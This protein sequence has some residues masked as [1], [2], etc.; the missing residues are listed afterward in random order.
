MSAVGQLVR[1]W[2]QRRRWSQAA[3]ADAAEVSARHLSCIETGK[4]N[5]SQQMVLVLASALDIPLRQR[6]LLLA[7]AG[8]APAY[9]ETDLDA[10]EMA[11]V[12]QAVTFLLDQA[13]PNG[14]ALVDRTYTLLRANR[15]LTVLFQAILGGEIPPAF[16]VCEAIFAELRPLCLNWNEVARALLLRVHREASVDGDEELFALLERMLAYDNVPGDWLHPTSPPSL[17]VPIELS[18]MGTRVSLF[19]T[20]TTLGTPTDITLSELRIE[21]YFPADAESAAV[22]NAITA[23]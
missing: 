1:S 9:R 5:P 4:A 3:L 17:L 20:I 11:Q 13:E 19:T 16:N 22:L 15:P 10:P 8:F 21:T 6:N 23:V 14:A 12:R 2:R 7:A 18:L